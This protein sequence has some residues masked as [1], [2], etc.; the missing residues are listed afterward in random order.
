MGRRPAI[1]R[2]LRESAAQRGAGYAARDRNGRDA[3]GRARRRTRIG[4]AQ[5]PHGPGGPFP[6]CSS[7][8]TVL[9]P[10]RP[11]FAT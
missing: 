7:R 1:L 3:V 2:L 6:A 4:D 8:H 10:R 11:S 5:I 9:P